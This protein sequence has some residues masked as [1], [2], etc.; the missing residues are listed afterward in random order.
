MVTRMITHA[1][2]ARRT[3]K[4]LPKTLTLACF[5]AYGGRPTCSPVT[6]FANQQRPNLMSP[7]PAA[8]SLPRCLVAPSYSN[9]GLN[10]QPVRRHPD[11]FSKPT[12]LSLLLWCFSE[13]RTT[14]HPH[15]KLLTR[16]RLTPGAS[17]LSPMWLPHGRQLRRGGVERAEEK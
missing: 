7:N 5:F 8:M 1:R 12:H 11:H 15:P 17:S 16:C 6:A 14:T 9:R 2:T 3:Q 4:S 13:P 10:E